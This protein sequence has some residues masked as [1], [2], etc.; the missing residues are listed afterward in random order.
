MF[1]EPR[2][3]VSVLN[4]YG[5]CKVAYLLEVVEYIPFRWGGDL[6]SVFRYNYLSGI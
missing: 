4:F 2:I 5:N 3:V 1:F 6:R